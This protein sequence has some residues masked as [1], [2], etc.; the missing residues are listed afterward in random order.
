MA[1][2]LDW[3]ARPAVNAAARQPVVKS[4]FMSLILLLGSGPMDTQ[5]ESKGKVQEAGHVSPLLI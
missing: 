2:P 3:A 5:I 1:V 4:R